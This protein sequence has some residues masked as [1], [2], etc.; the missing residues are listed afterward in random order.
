MCALDTL[1]LVP[2]HPSDH[3]VAGEC[4]CLALSP[5]QS[6]LGFLDEP[7]TV[8]AS[9]KTILAKATDIPPGEEAGNSLTD[10]LLP[11]FRAADEGLSDDRRPSFASVRP[12][13]SE[14]PRRRKQRVSS[15]P[16]PSSHSGKE[17]EASDVMGIDRRLQVY[18]RPPYTWHQRER[19]NSPRPFLISR[20]NTRPTPVRY[21]TARHER[22]LQFELLTRE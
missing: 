9:E 3:F 21:S 15:S 20:V 8:Q 4:E 12:G 17:V 2:L 5:L 11:Y 14:V 18:T 19:L 13:T 22:P 7:R 10:Y 1:L 6:P 16:S